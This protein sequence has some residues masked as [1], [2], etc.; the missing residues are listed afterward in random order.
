[1]SAETDNQNPVVN[2]SLEKRLLERWQIISLAVAL[3]IVTAVIVYVYLGMK[4]TTI[5]SVSNE[6]LTEP[7][8][9]TIDSSIGLPETGSML[10]E[11][12]MI[13]LNQLQEMASTT[14]FE[15]RQDRQ[16]ALGDI[17]ATT[18]ESIEISA[19]ERLSTLESMGAV[20][21]LVE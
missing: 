20:E 7:A 21:G 16:T 2:D 6:V 14:E 15:S 10:P 19:E 13:A 1:M 12:R 5:M 18:S 8:T 4:R 9:T 11:E 3:L 17:R